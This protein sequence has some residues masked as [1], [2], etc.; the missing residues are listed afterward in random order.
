MRYGLSW[1]EKL[2]AWW[3]RTW[4]CRILRRHHVKMG[5]RPYCY[6]CGKRP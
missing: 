6:R 3:E 2:D 1:Q 4:Q 5:S